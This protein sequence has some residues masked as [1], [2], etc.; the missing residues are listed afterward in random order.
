MN[1]YQVTGELTLHGVTRKVTL[2]VEVVR[3][4]QNGAG[5]ARAWFLVRTTLKRKDYGITWNSVLD[6][7][8]L[9]VGEDVML[10]VNLVASKN[11]ANP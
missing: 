8:T 4:V 9:L 7:A 5:L 3:I 10:T 6:R 1:I 11:T 2:P